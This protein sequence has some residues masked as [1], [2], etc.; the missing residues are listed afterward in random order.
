MYS[1]RTGAGKESKQI[2]VSLLNPDAEMLNNIVTIEVQQ[3][4][5]KIHHEQIGFVLKICKNGLK[6][7][8]MIR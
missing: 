6:L 2:L 5:S 7:E 8:S 1:R 3:S 4:I